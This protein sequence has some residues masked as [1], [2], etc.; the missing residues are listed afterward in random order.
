V[1]NAAS[2]ATNLVIDFQYWT[3]VLTTEGAQA[4]LETL[5]HVISQLVAAPDDQLGLI[6]LICKRQKDQI[7]HW[8]AGCPQAVSSCLHDMII[9]G[10]QQRAGQLSHVALTGWDREMTYEQLLQHARAVADEIQSTCP[11]SRVRVPILFEKSIYTIVAMLGILMSGNAFVPLDPES[12]NTRLSFIVRDAGAPVI[13]TSYRYRSKARKLCEK[14]VIVVGAHQKLMNHRPDQIKQNAI[15]PADTAYVLYTSGSTGHPKGVI[16]SHRAVCT[17]I[18]A[19]SEF[20]PDNIRCLQFASYCFDMVVAEIFP[21]LVSGGVL[22]VP[23]DEERLEDIASF[24]AEHDINY[25]CFTPSFSATLQA[26]KMPSLETIMLGGEVSP[27]KVIEMWAGRVH[28][29]NGYGPT[30]ATVSCVIKD[31]MTPIAP[32]IAGNALACRTWV[33]NLTNHDL[34]TPIG[35]IG[36][37][38]VEGPNVGDGYLNDE[39]RTSEVFLERAARIDSLP[40]HYRIYKTGDLCRYLPNGE[41]AVLGRKDDQV[42]L[43]GQRLDVGEVEQTALTCDCV[44]NCLITIPKSGHVPERLVGVVALRG[45]S[46]TNQADLTLLQTSPET[47]EMLQRLRNHLAERLPL[48]MQPTSWLCVNKLPFSVSGKLNRTKIKEWIVSQDKTHTQEQTP[49]NATT[50]ATASSHRETVLVRIWA[51]AL[52]PSTDRIRV[53]SSFLSHGGDSITAMQ[54]KIASKHAGIPVTVHDLLKGKTIQAICQDAPDFVATQKSGTQPSSLAQPRSDQAFPLSPIQQL[55]LDL[56]GTVGN[57]FNQSF[58]VRVNDSIQLTSVQQG[59]NSILAH[60]GMLRA[61]LV[62]KAGCWMQRIPEL[63]ESSTIT[64]SSHIVGDMTELSR[65]AAQH[66]QA[67]NLGDGP[68]F[69][70]VLF[71]VQET[72]AQFLLLLAHHFFVDMVSWRIIF[73]DL[74]TVLHGRTLSQSSGELS[75]KSWLQHQTAFARTVRPQPKWSQDLVDQLSNLEY[76]AVVPNKNTYGSV[77]SHVVELSEEVSGKL[78]SS[79]SSGSGPGITDYLLGVAAFTFQQSFSDRKPPVFYVEGHGRETWDEESIDPSQICGRFTT[80]SPVPITRTATL[81]EAINWTYDHRRHLTRNGFDDFSS[82]YLT[83]DG[84]HASMSGSHMELVFNYLGQFQQ[85]DRE[86]SLLKPSYDLNYT[87]SEVDPA[88]VRFTPIEIVC[89]VEQNSLKLRFSF[90]RHMLHMD[91]LQGWVRSTKECLETLAQDTTI[92]AS[93]PHLPR[94]LKGPANEVN[95]DN[96]PGEDVEQVSDCT[97]MQQF[98]VQAHLSNPQYYTTTQRYKVELPAAKGPVSADRLAAAWQ[99]VVDKHQILRTTLIPGSPYSPSRQ[100][101][102]RRMTARINRLQGVSDKEAQQ[103]DDRAGLTRSL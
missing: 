80:V 40:G 74:D 35:G 50:N 41:L 17:F 34:L 52:N 85:L 62:Y 103:F 96:L 19:Y 75:F 58:L 78:L 37:L 4:V 71:F 73:A 91:R 2:S 98:F 33:V 8:N 93:C 60:H 38:L 9:Q 64:V 45:L 65:I 59:I 102:Y 66:Q 55:Y 6:D 86:D 56:S 20:L 16:I 83:N 27:K 26:D 12:P 101:A 39:E 28:M 94:S 54:T 3:S 30:E 25:A 53:D 29:I 77:V 69:R 24:V 43:N 49:T 7:M 1:V 57:H 90:C 63:S 61:R 70:A 88:Q 51:E 99:Q 18:K 36:E 79:S 82:R 42:K 44:S 22:C 11:D 76:W 89:S 32:K 14:P 92:V 97:N 95:M 81:A 72:G 13:L 15:T 46:I 100:V 68:V 21:P 23:H 47:E 67:L 31:G 10:C 5:G 87:P 84:C 48:Y